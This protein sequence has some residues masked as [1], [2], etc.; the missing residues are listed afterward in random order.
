MGQLP[1][2]RLT[3]V[4]DGRDLP[5]YPIPSDV[6]LAHYFLTWH[7]DRWLGSELRLTGDLAVRALALDLFFIAQRQL[8]VGTLPDDDRQ[9]ARLLMIDE[10][11]WRGYRS[12]DPSPLHNWTQC[13][14]DGGEVRLM[15]PV[16]LEVAEEALSRRTQR[17]QASKEG[18]ARRKRNRVVSLIGKISS[19]AAGNAELVE[20][21]WDWL[22]ANVDGYFTEKNVLTAIEAYTEGAMDPP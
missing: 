10:P 16:V 7:F 8:P 21:V 15:H 20:F 4:S 17:L 18:V 1:G 14:C 11:A 9:L 5:L 22:C 6:R 19:R 12:M 13:V 2:N 3:V